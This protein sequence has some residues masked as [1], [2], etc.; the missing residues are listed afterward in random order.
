[1]NIWALKLIFYSKFIKNSLKIQ[2]I[3]PFKSIFYSIQ[4]I[5]GHSICYNLYSIAIQIVPVERGAYPGPLAPR[6]T[7]AGLIKNWTR[8]LGPKLAIGLSSQTA[9]EIWKKLTQNLDLT[10]RPETR[11]DPPG[12][13]TRAIEWKSIKINQNQSKI[14][15]LRVQKAIPKSFGHQ[16]QSKSI[17]NQ[18]IEGPK[19]NPQ[20]IRPSKSINWGSKINKNQSIGGPKGNS[21]VI[22]PSNNPP[23]FKRGPDP[24]SLSRNSTRGPGPKLAIGPPSRSAIEI[25]WKIAQNLAGGVGSGF[26]QS[27]GSKPQS[28]GL[29]ILIP[30]PRLKVWPKSFGHPKGGSRPIRGVPSRSA[31]KISQLGVKNQ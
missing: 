11:I 9:I 8:G 18:S 1:M 24:P 4:L 12:L 3:R 20:V 14:N 15:Q 2:V 26:R 6:G 25:D 16:N 28:N 29:S 31:I 7:A 17:K 21:L 30:Y 27:G 5:I 19:G 22:R 13:Q 10:P 23:R